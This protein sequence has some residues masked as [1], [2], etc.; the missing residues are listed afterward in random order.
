MKLKHWQDPVNALLGAWLAL[1]PWAAGYAAQTSATYNAIAVGVL[2][3]A[4]ALGAMLAPKAWEEWTEVVLGLWL[5]AAP[6]LL[7][8]HTADLAT[9]VA[10]STGAVVVVL[11]LWAL[12][13]DDDYNPWAQERTPR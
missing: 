13:A 11:A 3:I 8:F 4:A 2:L 6:R 1:S 5:I 7:A 10:A 12:V 9:A